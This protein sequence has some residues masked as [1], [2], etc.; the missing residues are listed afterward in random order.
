M[1][2]KY[3]D[4]QLLIEYLYGLFVISGPAL[5][6]H[7]NDTMSALSTGS[8][9][10]ANASI[11]RRSGGESLSETGRPNLPKPNTRRSD[12]STGARLAPE[13]EVFFNTDPYENLDKRSTIRLAKSGCITKLHHKGPI[14][15]VEGG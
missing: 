9:H 13:I 5:Q 4:I 12:H 10:F 11:L 6:N 1:R 15:E 2:H 8:V 14:K 3:P 7:T